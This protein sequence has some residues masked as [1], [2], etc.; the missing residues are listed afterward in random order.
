MV[1]LTRVRDTVEGYI[2]QKKLFKEK[3]FL[4]EDLVLLRERERE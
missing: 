1:Q 3:A 2:L 4:R